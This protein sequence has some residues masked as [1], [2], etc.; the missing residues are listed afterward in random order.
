M[1]ATSSIPYRFDLILSCLTTDKT[2]LQFPNACVSASVY[3][4][5]H[6]VWYVLV[7]DNWVWLALVVLA[8][9]PMYPK[10]KYL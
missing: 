2:G 5:F 9:G 4:I 6:F 1:N 10:L 8:S 7:W 3:L